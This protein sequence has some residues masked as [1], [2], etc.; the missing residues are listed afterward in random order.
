MLTR[1]NL[2]IRQA[3]LD[4]VPIILLPASDA[5]RGPIL[6][7][8]IPGAARLVQAT[9]RHA[10][11]REALLP[12]AFA[13]AGVGAADT[14]HLLADVL[15][16]LALV[17]FALLRGFRAVFLRRRQHGALLDADGVGELCGIEELVVI[18]A[19]AT[20][21]WGLSLVTTRPAL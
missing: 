7:T 2:H 8:H 9:A 6:P 21:A 3:K 4:K 11:A 17:V 13:G 1:S 10:H 20:G 16:L 5:P 12:L 19:L 14:P 15:V 18:I